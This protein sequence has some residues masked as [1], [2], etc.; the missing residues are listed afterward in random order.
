MR[1]WDEPNEDEKKLF[2]RMAGVFA[3]LSEYTDAQ[4]GRIIDDLEESGQ[5]EQSGQLDNTLVFRAADNVA[6][7]VDCAS[8]AGRIERSGDSV[9]SRVGGDAPPTRGARGG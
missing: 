8:R 7:V 5:L 3:G 1:P 6:M 2:A 9:P 4:I